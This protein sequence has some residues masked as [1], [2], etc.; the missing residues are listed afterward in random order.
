[1]LMVSPNQAYVDDSGRGQ[2]PVFVLAGFVASAERWAIFADEW[3]AA[4]EGPHARGPLAY[5]K[6]REAAHFHGQFERWSEADRDAL[7]L[8]LIGV[9]EKCLPTGIATV[10]PQDD[11]RKIFKGKISRQMDSPYMLSF[12]S[13]MQGMIRI[14]HQI[15]TAEPVDF[16]FDEQGK[17]IGRALEAWKYFTKFTPPGTEAMHG[18]RPISG[19][20]RKLVPLQAADLLAWRTRR[21][22]VDAKTGANDAKRL[23]PFG[24]LKVFTTTWDKASMLEQMEAFREFR[25][26][27]GRKFF[28][29]SSKS[30]RPPS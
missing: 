23:L 17:E 29:E 7:L 27:T 22:A 14:Q 12:Y 26:V 15:G 9:I 13:I 28:Y 4:L 16:I 21:E 10:V 25:R 8:R 24:S 6:M 20:D 19:D 11:F 18:E 2:P 3:K 1:M 30:G 5:F